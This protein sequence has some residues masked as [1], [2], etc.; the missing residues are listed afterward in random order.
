MG[1][2]GFTCSLRRATSL[3][4]KVP[5]FYVESLVLSEYWIITYTL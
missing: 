4:F 5:S 2:A 3:V 1:M